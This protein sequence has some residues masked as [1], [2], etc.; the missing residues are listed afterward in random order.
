LIRAT[1]TGR[2][3]IALGGEPR[4]APDYLLIG[5]DGSSRP[6]KIHAAWLYAQMVRWRQASDSTELLATAEACFRSDLYDAVLGADKAA[7]AAPADGIGAFSGPVFAAE[8]LENYLAGWRK[9][10]P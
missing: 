5:R 1:F 6:E 2:L 3:P 4:E 10:R 9:S 8:D 7:L